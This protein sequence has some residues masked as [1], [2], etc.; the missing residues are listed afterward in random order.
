MLLEERTLRPHSVKERGNRLLTSVKDQVI[1]LPP[2]EINWLV[3]K[4]DDDA[5]SRRPRGTIAQ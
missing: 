4:T 2:Y 3:L 1:D 5:F